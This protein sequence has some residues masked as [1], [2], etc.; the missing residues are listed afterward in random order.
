MFLGVGEPGALALFV[1][2]ATHFPGTPMI[3]NVLAK[4]AAVILVALFT[5]IALA[6]RDWVAMILLW[7]TC[8]YAHLF[9]RHEQGHFTL[10]RFNLFKKKPKLR[11]L[12]K[13]LR[14]PPQIP[15]CGTCLR[16]WLSFR[17]E[18]MRNRPH[19]E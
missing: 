12:P 9:V 18:R 1:A 3:F 17:R 7:S 4:W 5:C 2:F 6:Q 16:Q 8:G 10:P 19:R 11:V 15:F 13:R 14:A